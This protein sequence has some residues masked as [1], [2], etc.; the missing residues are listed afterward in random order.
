MPYIR[1][2]NEDE[3]TGTVAEDYEYLSDSYSKLVGA[4]M[5]TP[6][7]YRTSSLVDTY[8]RFGALQNR[9]LTNDGQHGKEDGPLPQ[10]LVNFGV[11]IN[12]SCFY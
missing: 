11:A 3:A 7:V 8:F 10:I 2:V 1:F 4:T 9:V 12:S 6:Q 5:A